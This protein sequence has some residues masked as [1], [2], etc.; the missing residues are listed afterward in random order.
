MPAPPRFTD[1]TIGTALPEIRHAVT[2]E[3]IDRYAVGSLDF[4]PVHID[5]EWCSRA[6]VFG[7]PDTVLH[8][9]ASMSLMTSVVTRA[10]GALAAV[11]SVDSKFTKPTPPGQTLTIS[12]AVAELH[13][14]GPGRNFVVVEVKAADGSGEVVGISRIEVG[15]PD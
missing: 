5:P 1:V 2:Q 8:G 12:G 6:R 13:P 11:R 14:V 7:I 4:N 10:W 15:L 9:M 3:F